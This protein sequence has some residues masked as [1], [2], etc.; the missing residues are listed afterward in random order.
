[1]NMIK[2]II[3]ILILVT[4]A[5]WLYRLGRRCFCGK[6]KEHQVRNIA[7]FVIAF[8]AVAAL[9]ISRWE[10][11]YPFERTVNLELYAVIDIPEEHTLSRPDWHAI[12]EKWGIYSGSK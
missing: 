7:R 10:Y 5:V 8:I 4:S 6:A 11:V 1:M 2:S 3:M 9:F 12:Y